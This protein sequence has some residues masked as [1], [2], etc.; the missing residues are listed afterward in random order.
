MLHLRFAMLLVY[1]VLYGI[2]M[3]SDL[4]NFCMTA[5]LRVTD[6]VPAIT[7]HVMTANAVD[8]ACTCLARITLGGDCM[9]YYHVR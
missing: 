5:S 2:R 6:V 9:L 3:I 7:V 4:K 1:S 8:T